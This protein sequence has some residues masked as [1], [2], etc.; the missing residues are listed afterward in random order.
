MPYRTDHYASHPSV[1]VMHLQYLVNHVSYKVW[2]HKPKGGIG[3]P[4]EEIWTKED[5]MGF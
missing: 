4:E 3:Q 1:S 5:L 2:F